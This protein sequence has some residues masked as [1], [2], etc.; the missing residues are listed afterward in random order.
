[1][2]L[3][4]RPVRCMA[5]SQSKADEGSGGGSR[6]ACDEAG[7]VPSETLRL[8]ATG[9]RNRAHCRT[10]RRSPA[11]PRPASLRGPGVASW[12]R[13]LHIRLPCAVGAAAVSYLP[14]DRAGRQGKHWCAGS[15]A[16][17][18]GSHYKHS[19][20][21]TAE[22]SNRRLRRPHRDRSRRSTTAWRPCCS[23]PSCS[24]TDVL[25]GLV[26][27][28]VPSGARRIASFQQPATRA[29]ID[30]LSANA[31]AVCATYR[32]ELTRIVY[33]GGGKEQVPHG[34]AAVRGPAAV[35]GLAARPEHRSGAR[36][37][38]GIARGGRRAAGARRADEHAAGLAHHPAGPQPA[39]A[40]RVRARAAVLPGRSTCPT[41]RCAKS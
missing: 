38:G 10:D 40:R 12:L 41:R 17:I 19:H 37:A 6:R 25:N 27:A 20:G 34:G 5:P 33:E 2:A 3:G 32:A 30:E 9:V 16:P 35:R 21:Q 28:A 11:G 31:K 1:M 36:P 24:S 18:I 26:A 13:E 4:N 22:A 7:F 23:R 39:A 29:A 15:A 8:R 14:R